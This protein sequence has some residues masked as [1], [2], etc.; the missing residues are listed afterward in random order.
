MKK[1]NIDFFD[2]CLTKTNDWV[3]FAEAKNAVII[4][5]GSATLFGMQKAVSGVTDI[6]VFILIYL[7]L[8]TC[9]MIISMVISLYSFIPRLEM[10]FWVKKEKINEDADNPL[11]FGHAYKYSKKEKTFLE[12]INKKLNLS[13]KNDDIDLCYC[14]QIITN[15]EIAFLKFKAFEMAAWLFLSAIITPMGALI[16][17]LFRK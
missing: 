11:Y 2:K 1:D 12:L 4:A 13:E 3:K 6:N 8:F 5:L 17:Y 7:S 16:I 15:S 9:C 14:N 10:F